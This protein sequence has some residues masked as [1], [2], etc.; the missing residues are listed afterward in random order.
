MA[1]G[2]V[3]IGLGT[4]TAGSVRVLASYCGLWGMR[5]STHR[6]DM[7]GVAPLSPPFDVGA[8]T[9]SSAWGC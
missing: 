6:I 9:P 2:E 3:D 5:P 1:A 7:A 8:P 4:D